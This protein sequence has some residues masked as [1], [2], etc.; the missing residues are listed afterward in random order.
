MDGSVGVREL[1]IAVRWG[2]FTSLMHR[3]EFACYT[4]WSAGG[5]GLHIAGAQHD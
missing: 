4:S 5:C 3:S 1:N 2:V